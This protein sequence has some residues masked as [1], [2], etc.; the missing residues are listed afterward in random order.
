MGKFSVTY[1]DYS[2]ETST[3]GV[4]TID[5]TAGNFT[6]QTGLATALADA[7]A[8]VT[9]GQEVKRVYAAF[10]NKTPV[11]PATDK[12]I[13]IERKWL[14]SAVDAVN[15]QPVS[16]TIPTADSTFVTNN[17]DKMDLAGTEGAAL[18][19]AIEAFVRS[20]AG[21]AVTV[22]EIRLVGRNV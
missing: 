17:T 14:V 16:F 1:N 22:T 4:H 2:N 15:G 10:E 13:Q 5:L 12:D 20:V 21:N 3:M 18:V 9:K 7:V 8:A 19:S 11:V 6:A